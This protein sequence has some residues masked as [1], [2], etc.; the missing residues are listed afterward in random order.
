M[1][2]QIPAGTVQSGHRFWM[3]QHML[4]A[5]PDAPKVGDLIT[6]AGLAQIKRDKQFRIMHR[7]QAKF[8]LDEN[9]F[10]TGRTTVG[11][12]IADKGI[13]KVGVG[14]EAGELFPGSPKIGPYTFPLFESEDNQ[15]NQSPDNQPIGSGKTKMSGYST[16]RIGEKG[17]NVNWRLFGKD[18]PWIYSE[19]VFEVKPDRSVQT[20]QRA[21]VDISWRDGSVIQGD[22]QF[23]NLNIY[24]ATLDPQDNIVIYERKDLLEMEGKLA[25]FINSASG[26]WPEPNIP[27]SIQ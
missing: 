4:N 18:A 15:Y 14:L 19:M 27:P 5:A 16:A 9:G 1:I 17:R 25:P 24:K 21:S 26:Q 7:Y 23:N 3:T 11:E 8:M 2:G 20:T 10:I 13:T 6:T 12:H 22:K